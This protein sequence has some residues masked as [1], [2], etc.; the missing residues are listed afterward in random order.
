MRRAAASLLLLAAC[1]GGP[2][3]GA[4]AGS[5][6]ASRPPDARESTQADGGSSDCLPQVP[7]TWGTPIPV[8][9]NQYSFEGDYTFYAD[10]VPE[11]DRFQRLFIGLNAGMGVFQGGAVVPG[12]YVIEGDET[13][14]SWCGACVYL[15]VDDDGSAPSVLFMARTGKL[16][17]DSVGAE[18]HGSLSSADLVQIEIAYTGPSCDTEPWPCGNNGCSGGLC[19]LQFDGPGCQTHIDSLTF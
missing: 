6:D 13:D 9:T 17:I 4:D 7:D 18:I 8:D 5:A 11:P 1:G 19:G 12:S 10:L 16:T 15:A 3:G 2:S 14:F